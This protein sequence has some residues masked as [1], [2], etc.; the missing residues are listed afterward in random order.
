MWF[1]NLEGKTHSY[2]LRVVKR[3]IVSVFNVSRPSKRILGASA[4]AYS[5]VGRVRERERAQRG[6]VS[7]GVSAIKQALESQL[8]QVPKSF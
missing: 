5:V 4:L 6:R 3:S 1:S 2:G 8:K 7:K